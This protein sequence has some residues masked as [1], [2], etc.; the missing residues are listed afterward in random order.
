MAR[1]PP[2]F[3][4]LFLHA[5]RP[6]TPTLLQ[7]LSSRTMTQP[8]QRFKGK[9]VVEKYLLESGLKATVLRPVAFFENLDGMYV[10]MYV[11]M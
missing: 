2:E 4:R 11:C 9:V 5:S 8:Q 7:A 10:C 1:A 3:V 6:P